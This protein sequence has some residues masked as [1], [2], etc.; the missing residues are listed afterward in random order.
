M[1]TQEI[2]AMEEKL[3]AALNR[4]AELEERDRLRADSRRTAKTESEYFV[5]KD[6]KKQPWDTESETKK[7]FETKY[8][9]FLKG[10][11]AENGNMPLKS[12]TFHRFLA[13][14][15]KL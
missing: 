12:G 13:S 4:V 11:I 14:K 2:K 10:L 6:E 5:L 9:D 1:N 15:L 7:F 8:P 3:Q